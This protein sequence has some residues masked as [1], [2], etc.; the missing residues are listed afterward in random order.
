MNTEDKE[1]K[2]VLH[3]LDHQKAE[4]IGVE[5]LSHEA[6]LF[7]AAVTAAEKII[8]LSIVQ[9]AAVYALMAEWAQEDMCPMCLD[10]TTRIKNELNRSFEEWMAQRKADT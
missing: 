6:A 1:L 7:L 10:L 9:K 8:P 2:K 5:K 4:A 3:D